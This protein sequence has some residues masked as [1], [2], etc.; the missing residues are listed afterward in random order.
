MAMGRGRSGG[1]RISWRR[2]MAALAA[3]PLL[4]L[5]AA[6]VGALV[7]ANAGWREP[8][9]GITLFMRSNGVH[10]SIVVP[11]SAAGI[12]WRALVD[13]RDFEGG[14]RAGDHLAFGWGHRQFYLETPRWVDLK[15]QVAVRAL[16]GIGGTLMHVEHLHQPAT[17]PGQ[18]PVR[19]TA[20]QYRALAGFIAAGFAPA[21]GRPVAIPGYTASDRFYAARGRY[22]LF[23][24]SNSWT[25]E[26]LRHIGVRIGVW[27]PFASSI[28]W[29]FPAHDR[30]TK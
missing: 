15:P 1:G 5:L 18:R 13:P 4:Y 23:Y 24:T 16:S 27:T 19:V 22:N 12:D 14:M 2:P 3:A 20:M 30:Y 29:R 25:G 11:V 7:P 8:D 9:D 6:I 17:G 10:T 21:G 26:A 28:M